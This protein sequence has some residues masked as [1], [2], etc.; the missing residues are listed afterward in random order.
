MRWQEGAL[1]GRT[2]AG[3]RRVRGAHITGPLR[4]SETV[5]VIKGFTL[6]QLHLIELSLFRLAT[7]ILL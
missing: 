1:S 2:R 5:T 3:V 6:P 4:P 7:V